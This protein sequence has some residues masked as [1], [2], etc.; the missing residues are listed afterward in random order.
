MAKRTV[1]REKAKLMC[2]LGFTYKQIAEYLGCSVQWC[3]IHLNGVELD[4]DRMIDMFETYTED[5]VYGH[6]K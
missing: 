4:T 5:Y 6:N 2:S 1:N 3:A